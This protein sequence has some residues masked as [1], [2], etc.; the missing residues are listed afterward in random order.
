M[1]CV[2]IPSEEELSTPLHA[3]SNPAELPR[4]LPP[5]EVPSTSSSKCFFSQCGYPTWSAIAWLSVVIISH[6]LKQP[7]A[8]LIHLHRTDF[9]KM[10]TEER[11]GCILCEFFVL[12]Y[13][14]LQR[15]KRKKNQRQMGARR[16]FTLWIRLAPVF[17]SRLEP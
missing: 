6:V 2:C 7:L 10:L 17:F 15:K 5:E 9:P 8:M 16:K 13:Q 11:I 4:S 12:F 1:E 14:R 3:S